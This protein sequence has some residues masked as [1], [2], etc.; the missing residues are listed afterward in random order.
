MRIGTRFKLWGIRVSL[1]IGKTRDVIGVNSTIGEDSHII[2]WEF[3][4]PDLTKIRQELWATQVFHSLPNIHISESHPGGGYHAYCLH[5]CTFV[6]SLHIVSGTKH[7]DPRYITMSAMRGHWT[8]RRTTK[9]QGEPRYIETLESEIPDTAQMEDLGSW[10]KY[11]VWSK[12]GQ[13]INANR[14]L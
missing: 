1:V 14:G 10:V 12:K 2:M 9:G 13:T 11:E 8:L 6:E 5:K 4:D 3:D 7:V